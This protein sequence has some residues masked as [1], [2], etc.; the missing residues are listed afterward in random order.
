MALEREP[1]SKQAAQA[2]ESVAEITKEFLGRVLIDGVRR[3]V[4]K[5]QEA[6]EREAQELHRVGA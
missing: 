1:E 3:V 6:V 4:P 5:K 2:Q